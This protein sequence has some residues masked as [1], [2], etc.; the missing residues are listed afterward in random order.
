M[1]PPQQSG[2]AVQFGGVNGYL[3]TFGQ[4]VRTSSTV[5]GYS[6]LLAPDT[7]QPPTASASNHTGGQGQSGVQQNLGQ[8][9]NWQNPGYRGRRQNNRRPQGHRNRHIA[10]PGNGGSQQSRPQPEDEASRL[11]A[12]LAAVRD[13][14]GRRETQLLQQLRDAERRNGGS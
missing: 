14:A 13:E 8:R 1:T 9:G 10:G 2:L 5:S 3:D 12:Q 6:W 4:Q 7:P 11:R